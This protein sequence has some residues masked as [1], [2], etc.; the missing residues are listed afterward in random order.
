LAVPKIHDLDILLGILRPHHPSLRSVRHG[1]TF[2]TNFAVT[3]RYP[4]ENAR[5]RQAL[6]AL[7][8]AE[9]VRSVCRAL[10]GIRTSRTRRKKSP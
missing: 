5:K 6:S 10:L 1:L 4:G 9:R 8:W 3:I 2:L 7:R